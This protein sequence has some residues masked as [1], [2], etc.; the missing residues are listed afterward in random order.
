MRKSKAH[1]VLHQ[2]VYIGVRALQTVGINGIGCMDSCPKLS[3]DCT[4]GILIE[5]LDNGTYVGL[6]GSPPVRVIDLKTRKNVIS[7]APSFSKS[8]LYS[9]VEPPHLF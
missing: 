4:D 5:L 3:V 9:K 7:R 8:P 6:C 1:I 2:Q